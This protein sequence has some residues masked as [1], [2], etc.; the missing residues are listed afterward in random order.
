MFNYM[1]WNVSTTCDDLDISSLTPTDSD[2]SFTGT[3]PN[4]D[5]T[6]V[7]NITYSSNVYNFNGQTYVSTIL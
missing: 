1:G 6:E 5:T 7:C 2:F 4:L 3:I